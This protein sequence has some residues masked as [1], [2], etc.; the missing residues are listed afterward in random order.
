MGAKT[1]GQGRPRSAEVRVGMV[2]ANY[3]QSQIFSTRDPPL[4]SFYHAS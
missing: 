3:A 1:R 4:L 2:E